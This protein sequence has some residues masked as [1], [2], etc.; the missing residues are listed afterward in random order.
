MH[1]WF[2]LL[3]A[4]L[5]APDGDGHLATVYHRADGRPPGIAAAEGGRA[6]AEHLRVP[7]HFASPGIPNDEGPRCARSSGSRQDRNGWTAR[8]DLKQP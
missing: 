5:E 8:D 7:F 4:V 2:V 3:V 1:D 6:L